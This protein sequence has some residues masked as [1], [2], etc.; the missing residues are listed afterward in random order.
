MKGGRPDYANLWV[1]RCT[2][3]VKES[4]Q[5]YI[6]EGFETKRKKDEKLAPNAPKSIPN[7]PKMVR[8]RRQEGQEI[9]PSSS[10]RPGSGSVLVVGLGMAPWRP[11]QYAP[12]RSQKER[13]KGRMEEMRKIRRVEGKKGRMSRI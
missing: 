5:I 6:Q 2:H 1:R 7:R 3:K 12:D 10:R 13:K 8:K 4:M 11:P 9:Q